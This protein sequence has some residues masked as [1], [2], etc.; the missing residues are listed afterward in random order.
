MRRRNITAAILLT[1]LTVGYGLVE[2]R[3]L[4]AGPTLTVSSPAAGATEAGALFNVR[5]VAT[6]VTKLSVNGRPVTLD[7]SGAFNE[8]LVTPNGLGVI[9]VEGENRFGRTIER[10]IEFVGQ[11]AEKGRGSPA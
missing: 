9:V 2:A 7:M 6:N 4:I 10:H 3:T 1:A 5:G 8:T 11:P